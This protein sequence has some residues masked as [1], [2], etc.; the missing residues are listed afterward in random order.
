[1]EKTTIKAL[2]TA[3][4]KELR[5][6]DDLP[7]PIEKVL[8]ALAELP[9]DKGTAETPKKASNVQGRDRDCGDANDEWHLD[10]SM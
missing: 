8:Q 6:M 9:E 3:L 10:C 4:K 5:I 2:G 1:M 7:F